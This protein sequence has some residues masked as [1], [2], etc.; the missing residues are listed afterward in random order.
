MVPVHV[1]RRAGDDLPP[2]GPVV[3]SAISVTVVVA[4]TVAVVVPIPIS[5]TSP[6]F[7]FEIGPAAV[8]H[9][10]AAVIRSPAV[11][12]R[13]R[14]LAALL[15]QPSPAIGRAI[16]PLAVVGGTRNGL[17]DA[18]RNENHERGHH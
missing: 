8:I 11:A 17:G 12:L 7:D 1:I 10:N 14:G 18:A 13:T 2:A 4:I 16:M 3:V 6:L 9:P 5:V 15:H